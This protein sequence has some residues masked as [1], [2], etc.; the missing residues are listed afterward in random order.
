MRYLAVKVAIAIIF[1]CCSTSYAD[2]CGRATKKYNTATLSKDLEKRERLLKESLAI[3]CQDDILLAKI[4]NN[5]ADTYEN[6]N[7]LKKAIGLYLKSV[8][9]NLLSPIPYYSLGDVYKKL[10]RTEESKSWYNKAFLAEKYLPKENIV[11]A[12]SPKRSILVN[13]PSGFRPPQV[14]L[15]FGFDSAQIS[16]LAEKQLE[17][18]LRAIN[19]PEL[20]KYRFRLAGHTCDKGSDSY[21]LILSEQRAKAVKKWLEKNNT[22]SDRLA[23]VGYGERRPITNNLS[24]EERRENRRVEIR[25]VGTVYSVKRS[26]SGSA[27]G[28]RLKKM[29]EKL[30]VKENY[31]QAIVS[32][33]R[34][35]AYFENS[36]DKIGMQSV[37]QDLSIAYQFLDNY[38]KAKQYMELIESS[39]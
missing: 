12:I 25:P 5:L 18:L 38:D 1:A 19:G 2:D 6:Q 3:D 33:E 32:F 4:L 37:F 30:L 15:Y 9:K 31:Q 16:V 14:T 29:G 39:K 7:Q 20:K 11:K 17:E 24:E 10:N 27:E 21:N 22:P 36:Q 23:V 13:K 28:F 26:S 8:D 35:L 34:A